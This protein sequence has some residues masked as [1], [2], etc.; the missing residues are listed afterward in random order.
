MG[1]K[2]TLTVAVWFGVRVVPEERPLALKPLPDTLTEETVTLA[3]PVL[4][5]VTVFDAFDPSTILPKLRLEALEES[6]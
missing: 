5:S 4:V 2:V 3:L 6:V 1:S